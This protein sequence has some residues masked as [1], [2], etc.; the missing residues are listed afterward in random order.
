VTK[1]LRFGN[2]G[3]CVAIGRGHSEKLHLDLHDNNTLYT[4]IM[5]TGAKTKPWNN[6]HHQGSSYLPT[7]G[8]I[9]PMN[10]GDMVFFH[11]SEL[12][13]LVMKLDESKREYRTVVTTCS[14]AHLSEVPEHPPAFCLPWLA[15]WCVFA[16]NVAMTRH[17]SSKLLIRNQGTITDTDNR[18]TSMILCKLDMIYGEQRQAWAQPPTP[19]RLHLQ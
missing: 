5:V 10:I 7:L 4:S 8:I 1:I 2:L 11:A 3:I 14:C 6:S 18:P 19:M 9:V 16:S 12:P 13:H 17:M 15:L